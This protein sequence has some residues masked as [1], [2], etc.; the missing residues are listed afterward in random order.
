M[1]ERPKRKPAVKST[2]GK[3]IRIGIGDFDE[4]TS[5]FAA[6]WKSAQKARRRPPEERLTFADLATLLRTLTPRRWAL[7][8]DL[9]RTG[10]SSVRA[11]SQAQERDYKT[12]HTEVKELERIGL[13]ARDAHGRILVPW[14]RIAAELELAA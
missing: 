2:R 6:V 5:R 12:V 10:P 9:R 4:A 7:L 8:R 14:S 1:K 13:I 3:T 11:L